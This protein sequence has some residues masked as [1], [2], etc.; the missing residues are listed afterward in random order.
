MTKRIA[1]VNPR[2]MP[3]TDQDIAFG[4]ESARVGG[5]VPPAPTPSIAAAPIKPSPKPDQD[6]T[7][8]KQAFGARE[9][10]PHEEDLPAVSLP[11]TRRAVLAEPPVD[12][13]PEVPKSNA[14]RRTTKKDDT[15]PTPIHLGNYE[16]QIIQDERN[17]RRR[18]PR[19][20]RPNN[21]ERLTDSS[22]IREAIRYA[23]ASG[24]F[25][26]GRK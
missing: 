6:F 9:E 22:L 7:T 26:G 1:P 4:S 25:G 13:Q 8:D 11:E 10:S 18:L 15:W 16:R 24:H 19:A 21:Q 12:E 23:R 20:Q 17:R 2:L 14:P 5:G 3:P